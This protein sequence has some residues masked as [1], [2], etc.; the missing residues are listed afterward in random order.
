MVVVAATMTMTTMMMMMM[1]M[2]EKKKKRRR[3]WKAQLVNQLPSSVM[4]LVGPATEHYPKQ[5]V[6]DH[7]LGRP[8]T[9]LLKRN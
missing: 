5:S 2:E 4:M 8:H 6:L 3:A 1:M 9:E 7:V